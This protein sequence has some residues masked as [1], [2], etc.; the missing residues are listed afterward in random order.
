MCHE[1]NVDVCD[2]SRRGRSEPQ[3]AR[4]AGADRLPRVPGVPGGR[5]PRGGS[6]GSPNRRALSLP[7]RARHTDRSRCTRPDRQRRA[8]SVAG[9][10]VTSNRGARDDQARDDGR[11]AAGLSD[12]QRQLRLRRDRS[13]GRHPLRPRRAAR[14]MSERDWRKRWRIP[15]RRSSTWSRTRT[16]SRGRVRAARRS[17]PRR[18]LDPAAHHRRPGQGES[19]SPRATSCSTAASAYARAWAGQRA[20]HPAAGARQLRRRRTIPAEGPLSR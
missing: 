10:I 1:A 18:A 7:G 13:R 8:P 6:L 15:A 17:C 9:Q 11:R 2:V 19:R 14:R 3:C 4:G 5:S 16:R 20:Q 12:R